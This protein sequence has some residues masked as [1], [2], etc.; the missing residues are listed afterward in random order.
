MKIAL[1]GGSFN[2]PHIGH[3]ALADAVQKQFGYDAIIFVPANISPFKQDALNIANDERINLLRLA[4]D[5]N[6]AF[7]LELCEIER[8]GVSY[9]IDTVRYIKQKYAKELSAPLG[10]I[11]GDDLVESFDKWKCA[12]DL[13]SE[14]QI[15]VARRTFLHKK[16]DFAYPHVQI[17]NAL[18]PISSSDIRERIA[19]KKSY[20]YLLCKSVYEYIAKH[21][22]YAKIDKNGNDAQIELATQKSTGATCTACV[23]GV[24][25][26]SANFN[27][28]KTIDDVRAY[29]KSAVKAS[30]YEHSLRVAEMCQVLCRRFGLDDAKGYLAGIAHDICKEAD[31]VVMISYA[32][33]D[34]SEVSLLER[35]KPS[36]LHGRAGAMMLKTNF[37]VT[38]ADVI[39]A[40]QNHTFGKAGMGRLALVLYVADKIEP[41]RS[42]VTPA[43][44]RSLE[45][46]SLNQ[47]A[48][49]IA[50]E[51]IEYLTKKGKKVAPE[52]RVFLSALQAGL[53]TGGL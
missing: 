35:A 36:L 13:A 19:H 18:L 5:G 34:G 45:A 28:D 9:T 40:V 53:A 17:Q 22:L 16:I 29:C 11:I 24:N 30:R 43:Y 46:L 33:R 23:P 37:G 1:L 50:R 21:N 25:A 3:L 27:I 49:R 14:A 44:L 6:D 39:E 32:L 10:L 38:D 31:D 7:K 20:R 47:L 8:G 48:M 2:P 41:G 26:Q 51:N 15:I 42:H 4:I 12:N 52:S